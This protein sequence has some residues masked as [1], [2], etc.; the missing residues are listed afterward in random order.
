MRR[1]DREMQNMEE[2]L[3]VIK[4]E[5][6]CCVAF[7]D[8]PCPY[9]IPLNYGARMENGKLV[10]YFHGAAEGTKLDRIRKNPNV[11]YTVYGGYE[12][13]FFED[14]PCKSSAGFV[15]VCGSG[16]AEFVEPEKAGEAL[17][18]LMNH[19]GG[20]GKKTFHPED[21]PA[22]AC[23]NIQVWRIVTETVTGK[24]HE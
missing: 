22:E 17:A 15:S 4:K 6:V 19:I 14:P 12:L 10:L 16:R 20:P 11:S 7:Q 2:I 5:N 1:K 21:F 9:L 3:E 24:H 18:V 8:E 23:R 13:R